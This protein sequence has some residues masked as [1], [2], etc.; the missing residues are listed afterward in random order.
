[1]IRANQVDPLDVNSQSAKTAQDMELVRVWE[2]FRRGRLTGLIT[3]I[4]GAFR[5]RNAKG[6]CSVVVD[7]DSPDQSPV[8]WAKI[9]NVDA[10]IPELE[11]TKPTEDT[12]AGYS[13]EDLDVVSSLQKSVGKNC[14]VIPAITGLDK[15]SISNQTAAVNSIA[16]RFKD[17]G[18]KALIISGDTDTLILALDSIKP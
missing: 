10:L 14:T 5:S 17:V 6:V 12:P 3:D 2:Q 9:R 15:E 13:Q 16:L 8:H 18:L 1:M 11:I 7:L 4:A